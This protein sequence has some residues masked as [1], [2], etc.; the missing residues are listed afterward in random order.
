MIRGLFPIACATLLLL[1]ACFD[2][3]ESWVYD[4]S[5]NAEV[6]IQCGLSSE[7]LEKNPKLTLEEERLILAPFWPTNALPPGVALVTREMVTSNSHLV[8]NVR[9]RGSVH[10]LAEAPFFKRRV[11]NFA[12]QKKGLT[13]M[14]RFDLGEDC[15]NLPYDGSAEF[16]HVFPGNIEKANLPFAG[17]KMSRRYKL[18]ELSSLRQLFFSASCR[19]P[20]IWPWK[21]TL[22]VLLCFLFFFLFSVFY[23]ERLRRAPRDPAPVPGDIHSL[24]DLLNRA[25][26]LFSTL[27]AVRDIT[28]RGVNEL[29]FQQ[30]RSN[31]NRVSHFL[32]S[33]GLAP[34]ERVAV[35]VPDGRWRNISIFGA[36]GAGG[37]VVPLDSETPS[38]KLAEII[39]T[40][41]VAALIA[42][43]FYQS[44]ASELLLLSKPLKKVLWL[45]D[46][47]EKN[48]IPDE[49]L[50]QPTS[51]PYKALNRE[52]PALLIPG[53]RD[54]VLSHGQILA[55]VFSLSQTMLLDARDVIM[56]TFR[57]QN[58]ESLA[59]TVFLP[60]VC[61]CRVVNA[62]TGDVRTTFGS[63]R[64]GQ[65]TVLLT[66][67]KTALA[68]FGLF[69]ELLEKDG[70]RRKRIAFARILKRLGLPHVALLKS[71]KEKYGLK[72]RR[73]YILGEVR[74]K[75]YYFY[76]P[77]YDLELRTGY[78]RNEAAGILLL[79][80]A[81]RNACKAQGAPL[82][83]IQVKIIGRDGKALKNGLEGRLAF[84]G[85]AVIK[86]FRSPAPEDAEIFRNGWYVTDT[87][88][89]ENKDGT[90]EIGCEKN[91][92]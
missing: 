85:P 88:A 2:Y 77:M 44:R 62:G 16:V 51:A 49:L 19:Y 36:L 40:R 5:G 29:N 12:R 27:P 45:R 78:A 58:M 76:A 13:L 90:I 71:L 43:E 30:L 72:L 80:D 24:V 75:E 17:R 35:L 11:I 25:S 55:A 15:A 60:L 28:D 3:R 38:E 87:A 34:R 48:I 82:P 22:Y 89:K 39:K 73:L 6:H 1:T 57:P 67:E 20:E 54:I 26:S 18:S 10:S 52:D 68:G 74:E 56:T 21:E 91:E 4:K 61:A 63:L 65:V 81:L 23:R 50:K 31:A 79:S 33:G 8:L 9:L 92:A 83:N 66:D 86:S 41:D 14:C 84:R 70:G 46:D 37:V 7:F 42:S 64:E 53:A 59:F 47:L 69:R 32:L